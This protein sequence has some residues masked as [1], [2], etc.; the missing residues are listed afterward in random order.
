MRDLEPL[1]LTQHQAL[2]SLQVWG[3]AVPYLPSFNGLSLESLGYFY[4]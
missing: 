1:F 4:L 2:R 3:W